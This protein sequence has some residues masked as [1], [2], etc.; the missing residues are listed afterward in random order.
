MKPKISLLVPT[1]GRPDWLDRFY[2]SAMAMAEHP[3][4]VEVVVYIDD[5]DDSYD[6]MNLPRLV[7]V[8]GPRIVLSQ[9]W[10]ACWEN[11]RGEYYG[12]M[13]DDIVFRSKH[14]D[15][16]VTGAIDAHSGKIAFVWGNDHS[17]ESQRNVFGTHGF[18]H[19]NW[20]DV[21][22]RFVPPYFVSDY[23]DTWFNDLAN[24]LN[25][26]VYI[27]EIQTEH[28]HFSMGKSKID[29]TTQDRLDRHEKN[30][31]RELYYSEELVLERQQE[32]EKLRKF[33]DAA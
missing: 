8:R 12:H 10:N 5:D 25:C 15:T 21:V 9:M 20:T 19:K 28:M 16:M 23:N 2:K 33:K 1:R 14:W 3:E 4:Q 11:A 26:A 32:A 30:D 17:P 13:G 27:H 18:I 31:P 7:K 22:G 29:K 24:M 6:K